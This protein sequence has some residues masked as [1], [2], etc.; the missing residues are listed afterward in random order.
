MK[1]IIHTSR[2]I[3]TLAL[4]AFALS[5]CG[6]TSLPT[7]NSGNGNPNQ[8]AQPV[9]GQP[10]T[11]SNPTQPSNPGLPNVTSSL[12][13]QAITSLG[14]DTGGVADRLSSFLIDRVREASTAQNRLVTTGTLTETAQGFAFSNTPAD[15]LRVVGS[16]GTTLEYTI[17]TIQ[18]ADG[19][20]FFNVSHTLEFR[21]KLTNVDLN[22]RSTRAGAFRV[23]TVTGKM[24]L[25]G[26]S[27][28]VNLELKS[29]RASDF[30]QNPVSGEVG[31]QADF[32]DELRGT[33]QTTGLS[34]TLHE[35]T[36]FKAVGSSSIVT[37]QKR[38][39]DHAWTENGQAF[40][41]K[42][43]IQQVFR[44]G[45]PIEADFWQAV[46]DLTRNGTRIGGF[47]QAFTG[48]LLEFF[49]ESPAGRV[50]LGT[51]QF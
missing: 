47:G 8:P 17:K 7:N 32:L 48:N 39:M 51:F 24:T 33:L 21:V 42:G 28:T 36:E 25:E 40:A 16:D 12:N 43:R 31:L 26:K 37:Q 30:S 10:S 5:A 23:L 20:R 41:L 1:Q 49:L 46:G 27:F 19:S 29:G 14:N 13:L 4:I 35:A 44:D 2:K 15:R 22:V 45:R 34:V 38:F 3:A 11:P 50:R 9:T 6:T 18:S